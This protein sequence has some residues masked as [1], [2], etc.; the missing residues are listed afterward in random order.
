MHVLVVDD[1]ADVQLLFQQRFRREL[2]TQQI[3]LHFAL[4]GEAALAYLEQSDVVPIRLILSDINMPG[5]N[6]FELLRT[7]KARYGHIQVFMI[8]AYH[9]PDNYHAARQHGADDYLAK[10]LDF[11]ALRQKIGAL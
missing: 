11:V 9:N 5:M 8:T 7:I 1:E 2:R 10:P 4:S 6:G 3:A